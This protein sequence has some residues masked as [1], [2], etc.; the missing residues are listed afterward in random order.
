VVLELTVLCCLNKC[1]FEV[2]IWYEQY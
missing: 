1:L 2:Y